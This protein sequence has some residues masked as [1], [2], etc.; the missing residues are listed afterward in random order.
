MFQRGLE[1]VAYISNPGKVSHIREHIHAEHPELIPKLSEAPNTLFSMQLIKPTRSALSRQIR[2]AVEIASNTTG[3]LVLNN[4]EEFSRCLIP[5]LQ[6][7][8]PQKT[9]IKDM[10][11]KPGRT[12]M[13]EQE[14]ELLVFTKNKKRPTNNRAG[15]TKKARLELQEA[16][17][18]AGAQQEAQQDRGGAQ[19]GEPNKQ[20]GPQLSLSNVVVEAGHP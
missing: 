2:E 6:V 7:E 13:E 18:E 17:D 16:R 11:T 4:K 19:Q 15:P 8:G 5:V 20:Q 3:G 12:T 9:K 14:E 1:H 10:P